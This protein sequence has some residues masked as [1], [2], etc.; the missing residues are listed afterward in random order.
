MRGYGCAGKR[1]TALGGRLFLFGLDFDLMDRQKEQLI[2][3]EGDSGLCWSAV[4]W[5]Y[6]DI[7]H[8]AGQGELVRAF[9]TE[10]C[11]VDLDCEILG[12]MEFQNRIVLSYA[13]ETICFPL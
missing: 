2:G 8:A 10:L 4:G 12:V 7:V 1:R 5:R 11:S 3:I 6:Y 13:A 9:A